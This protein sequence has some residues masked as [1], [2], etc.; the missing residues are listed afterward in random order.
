MLRNTNHARRLSAA[1]LGLTL[2]AGCGGSGDAESAPPGP[3]P[4]VLIRAAA[5]ETTG[6]GSSRFALSSTTAIGGKD[7]TL[8]G[9]GSYDYAKKIGQLSFDLP[10]A[11]GQPSGGTIEERIIGNDL[12]LMLPRQPDSSFFKLLVSD[13]AGTSLGNSTDPTASLQ[14][15]AGL[16]NVAE[17][18]T[19]R[20]RDVETTHYSGEYDVAQALAQAQ[21]PAKAILETTLGDAAIQRVPFDA[22]LDEQGRVVKFEQR[23]ELPASAQ[24]GGQPLISTFTIEL[25]DFGT[26]VDVVA[27]PAESV[28][29][30]APLLAS[31]KNVGPRPP[32][33][34]APAPPLPGEPA[35]PAPAPVG[36][37]AP[38][39]PAPPAPA[40]PAPVPPAPVQ[41]A[42]VP[43]S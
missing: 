5:A 10:G 11:G 19:E 6:A 4:D 12:Y 3:A 36:P 21:G 22:Y 43:A 34:P 23:L 33:P 15:L 24:T 13:V 16:V 30:G 40:P 26:V 29:D 20:V 14:A 35:P 25:F 38:A 37:V 9:E 27:P 41:P 8:A 7:V 31:L 18:G 2:L 39:P 1:V 28:R 32:A 17:V 42:P